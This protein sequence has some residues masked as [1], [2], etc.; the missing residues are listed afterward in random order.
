MRFGPS[1]EP[2]LHDAFV[3][4]LDGD[5]MEI[6]TDTGKEWVVGSTGSDDTFRSR[7]GFADGELLGVL[8]GSSMDGP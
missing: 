4:G 6:K 5:G 1:E 7:L 8:G 3:G 2:H